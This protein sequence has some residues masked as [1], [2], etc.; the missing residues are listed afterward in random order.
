MDT[1]LPQSKELEEAVLSALLFNPLMMNEVTLSS[2]DFYVIRH[3]WLYE[4]MRAVWTRVN[5]FD[6]VLVVEEL[7]RVGRLEEMGG[8]AF[9]VG[10][11]NQVS[12]SYMA[13]Q[14]A[15]DLRALA[16]RRA[17]VHAANEI[18]KLAY[19]ETLT[20]PDVLTQATLTLRQTETPTQEVLSLGEWAWRAEAE[21]TRRAEQGDH[22][23]VTGL[24]DVDTRLEGFDTQEGTMVLLCGEPGA[25]KTILWGQIMLALAAQAPGLGLSLEMSGYRMLYRVLSEKTGI[26]ALAMRR[27]K[28]AE[29]EYPRLVHAIEE[30]SSLPL[31]LSTT[32]LDPEAL[33]TL[34]YRMKRDEGVLWYG[35]DYLT[36]LKGHGKLE[37]WAR[38]EVLSQDLLQ[39]NRDLGICSLIIHTLNKGGEV[40]GGKGAQYDA[41]VI[42]TLQNDPH[43]A[44][45]PHLEAKLLT[46]QKV[47]DSE[48]GTGNVSLLKH[49]KIPRFESAV[50]GTMNI[51][52]NGKHTEMW[53]QK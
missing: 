34:L 37:K 52:G 41:D 2:A 44:P 51:N 18:A 27:G 1:L 26:S 20:L 43:T 40:A 19:D 42:C 21:I 25:G 4:A 11:L 30:L 45:P 35:L 14:Y 10:L 9:L 36:L 29:A 5:T 49:K 7:E 31:H 22:F 24:A 17:L 23:M 3:R 50:M 13:P 16:T 15:A 12:V 53:Y 6:F 46:F 8:P 33:H 39:I 32:R 28:V 38:A 48:T 47:R